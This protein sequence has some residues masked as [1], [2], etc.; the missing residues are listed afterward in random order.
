[1][2][3]PTFSGRDYPAATPDNSNRGRD[4]GGRARQHI[5]QPNQDTTSFSRANNLGAASQPDESPENKSNVQNSNADNRNPFETQS[6]SVHGFKQ[7]IQRDHV[8]QKQPR[9]YATS[10][11]PNQRAISPVREWTEN[12]QARFEIANEKM[13][14]GGF[15]SIRGMA[16]LL[17]LHG[18][19]AAFN[20]RDGRKQNSEDLGVLKTFDITY[21][22]AKEMHDF[23]TTQKLNTFKE[24]NPFLFDGSLVNDTSEK[25]KSK[26]VSRKTSPVRPQSPSIEYRYLTPKQVSRIK[27]ARKKY[28]ENDPS[29]HSKVFRVLREADEHRVKHGDTE[30]PY[31]SQE[32]FNS[33]T[34]ELRAW[35]KGQNHD[36]PT[37]QITVNMIKMAS[38][39]LLSNAQIQQ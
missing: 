30:G 25:P 6:S 1:M 15:G 5:G 2:I 17:I 21:Y 22:L 28:Q 27:V 29:R 20:Y 19:R 37:A 24:Q 13:D 12:Q 10:P 38:K 23:I 31:S 4:R 36:N 39:G 14:K 16:D 33:Y 32:Y 26:P 9:E 3:P 18:E 11:K 8:L 7:V 35:A 34:K